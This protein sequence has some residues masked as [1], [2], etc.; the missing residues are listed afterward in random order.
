MKN[1]MAK[2]DRYLFIIIVS[3]LCGLTRYYLYDNNNFNLF[4]IADK[5][6]KEI[7]NDLTVLEIVSQNLA[8]ITDKSKNKLSYEEAYYLHSNNLA[9]FIDARSANEIEDEKKD[10]T[11]KQ[12]PNSLTIPLED[13]QLIE[14]ETNQEVFDPN[15]E[16]LNSFFDVKATFPGEL[17]IAQNLKKLDKE[18]LYVVYCAEITCKKSD[19]LYIYMTKNF[20]FKNA[21]V[22]KGGWEEWKENIK[23]IAND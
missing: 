12:I 15:F 7:K 4:S 1:K 21:R 3:I 10:E 22:F 8:L 17:K 14:S 16:E 13:I 20:G 6:K 19:N 11:Y 23:E 5:N 9:I 2:F 18:L